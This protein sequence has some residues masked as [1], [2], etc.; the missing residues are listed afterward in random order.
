[1]TAYVGLVAEANKI[2][3]RARAELYSA[4]ADLVAKLAIGTPEQ[5]WAPSDLRDKLQNFRQ[6]YP[7]LHKT[8]VKK[9]GELHGFHANG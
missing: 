3:G 8:L 6:R 1:L 9:L 4:L 5:H 7:R 2:R